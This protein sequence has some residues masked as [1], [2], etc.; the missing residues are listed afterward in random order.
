MGVHWLHEIKYDGYRVQGPWE[1]A[2]G[3]RYNPAK[4]LVDP[5]AR[6]LSGELE[7]HPALFGYVGDAVDG[8]AR[9]EQ[10]SAPYVPHGVVVHD[11]FPWDGDRPLRTS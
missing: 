7:L 11:N 9:D 8:S 10:D 3:H 1:P 4:L 6:A 2:A 5:Y